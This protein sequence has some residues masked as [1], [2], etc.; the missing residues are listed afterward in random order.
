MQCSKCGSPR[1]VT[2]GHTTP[3]P[4]HD[5]FHDIPTPKQGV[6][7]ECIDCGLLTVLVPG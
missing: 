2:V 6:Q 1:L 3:I 5:P 4:D 7:V